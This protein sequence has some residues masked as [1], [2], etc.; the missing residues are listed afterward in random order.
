MSFKLVFLFD[1]DE[2]GI[3]CSTRFMYYFEDIYNSYEIK[4][5]V[6][7][8]KD[9]SDCVKATSLDFMKEWVLN[10]LR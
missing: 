1:N 4:C 3:N 6:E 2:A 7:L 5:P 10:K 9:I 8:G